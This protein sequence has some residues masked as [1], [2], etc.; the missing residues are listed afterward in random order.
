MPPTSASRR[1]TLR[2][3]VRQAS[4]P[5]P[6]PG[7]G[8]IGS[9]TPTHSSRRR[10]ICLASSKTQNRADELRELLKHHSYA[11]HVLDDPEIADAEYDR[12]YDELVELAR[13]ISESEIPPDSPPRRVGGPP[14]D[15]F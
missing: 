5:W 11:Y 3:R 12:L 10:R 1:S 2:P 9:R 15:K 14:S 7:A 6:L 4:T 13:H 8:S